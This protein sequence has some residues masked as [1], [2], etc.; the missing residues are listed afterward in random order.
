MSV[1]TY[2]AASNT[3]VQGY[4]VVFDTAG[5]GI[6][7]Q[8]LNSASLATTDRIMTL[9]NPVDIDMGGIKLT[10]NVIPVTM[11]GVGYLLDQVQP[12]PAD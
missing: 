7:Y 10:T 9:S 5:G 8:T 6:I 12:S 2:V 4:H 3:P 11:V 1:G